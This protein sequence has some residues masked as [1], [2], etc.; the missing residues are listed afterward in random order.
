MKYAY[1][2][3]I[4]SVLSPCGDVLMT[5]NNIFNMANLK[6]LRIISITDHNSMKQLAVCETLSHSY[7]LLWIPGVEITV[8]EDF[9]VLCYFKTLEDALEVDRLLEYYL[10]RVKNNPALYGEQAICDIEDTIIDTYDYLL[11]QPLTLSLQDLIELLEPFPHIL[12]YA[13]IDKPS[14]SGRGYVQKIPLDGIEYRN[15]QLKK[16]KTDLHSSDAHQIIDL[17]EATSD[18]QIDLEEL[19]IAAFFRYFGHD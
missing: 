9:D 15:P 7:D 4:H 19:S 6:G 14:R 10:P 1:D 11:I 12:V 17:L 5:P 2:L 8:A 16:K 3:H 18:N 13:H